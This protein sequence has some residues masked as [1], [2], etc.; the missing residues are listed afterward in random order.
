M[1]FD[2]FDNLFT[3]GRVSVSSPFRTDSHH[4]GGLIR[5]DDGWVLFKDFKFP[6]ITFTLAS[7]WATLTTGEP[8]PLNKVSHA[9]W[10]MRL[11]IQS[12]VI[13]PHRVTLPPFKGTPAEMK[14]YHGAELLLQCRWR[15]PPHEGKPV[16]MAREFMAG[17]CGISPCMAHK[18]KTS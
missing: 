16:M 1:G 5:A 18:T 17:W 3:A 2:A 10:A 13:S 12:G 11:L 7:L 8:H 4:S 14:F 9:T 6:N 15:Y